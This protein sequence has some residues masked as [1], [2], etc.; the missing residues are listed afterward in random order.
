MAIDAVY[1][2]VNYL[3][4]RWRES[5]D[6]FLTQE[7][8]RM[9]GRDPANTGSI[10]FSDNG[11]LRYSLRSLDRYAGFIRRVYIVVDGSPPEWLETSSP[12]V[13]VISHR[14]IF[15]E[16]FPLPVFSSDLIEAFLWKIPELSEHYIYFNDDVLLA[17]RC[18]PRDFFD[19]EGRSVVRMEPDLIHVPRGPVDFVYNQMLRNTARAVARRVPPRSRPRFDTR[20]PWVPLIARRLIQNR[21]PLNGTAH[22]AQPFHRSLWPR[23]HEVF[24]KEFD[25]LC[26]SR[27]RHRRGF[28]V[29][30]AYQYLAYER[31]KALFTF[32]AD[33]LIISRRGLPTDVTGL[34][35][36]VRDAARRGIKFF[37]FN[38]G[39]SVRE[40]DWPAFIDETLRGI[41][42]TPSRWEK[43]P[44]GATERSRREHLS[45]GPPRHGT[46][47][48]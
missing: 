48:S 46:S 16:R 37:C 34:Q 41:L 31:Q 26:A 39:V 2:W 18:T 36:E 5:H 25:A 7:L 8:K 28:C 38:D 6:R 44:G 40:I 33:E 10:R 3:D 45:G 9:S 42:D 21:L 43:R 30:L 1:T 12:D 35:E 14:D 19:A 47:P 20:K 11:E 17:A 29:N 22:I 4:P 23:F 32:E 27:F 15:P 13:Q 24:R